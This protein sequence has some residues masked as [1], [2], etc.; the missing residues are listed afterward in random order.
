[1]TRFH[2]VR[3]GPT[4]QKTLVGWRDVPADLSDTPALGRLS[5]GLPGHAI[6]ISSDLT[7]AVKTADAI[8]D[9]RRRLPHDP[10]LREF[11]FGDWDGLH[12]SQ[13]AET[14]PELSRRYWESPGSVAAPGGESWHA[15]EARVTSAI[16]GLHAQYRGADIVVVGHF[17]MILTQLRR[18]LDVPPETALGQKIDNLSV[19][20]LA[21]DDRGWSVE[22]VNHRF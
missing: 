7:R 4:H 18:A 12:F 16:D 2:L 8:A 1:M 10:A 3:H 21:L 19:T 14:H 22:R 6:V 15:A 9:G 11:D 17:G 13:A 20:S 5:A